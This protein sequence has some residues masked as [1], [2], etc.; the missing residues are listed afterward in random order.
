[1]RKNHVI[2]GKKCDVKKAVPKDGSDGRGGGRGDRGGRGKGMPIK[3]TSKKKKQIR[4]G[5]MD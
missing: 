3:T 4:Y 5:Y 1:M 2:C